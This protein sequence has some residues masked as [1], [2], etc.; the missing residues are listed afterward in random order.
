LFL[1]DVDKV[2][3]RNKE[4]KLSIEDPLY[5]AYNRLKI[6]VQKALKHHDFYYVNLKEIFGKY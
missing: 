2:L 6:K 1:F 4:I 3:Y 5:I